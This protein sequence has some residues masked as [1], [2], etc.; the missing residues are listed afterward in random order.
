[1]GPAYGYI[2]SADPDAGWILLRRDGSL[3]ARPFDGRRLEFTG[4][5]I[6]IADRVGTFHAAVQASSS[7]NG[8]L[9]YRV[10]QSE[11]IQLTWTDRNG[12]AAGR[13]GDPGRYPS[14][15]PALSP[16]AARIAITR[17]DPTAA[18]LWVLD[19]S[20][21]SSLQ[22][23]FGRY[24]DDFPVWSPDGRLIA[25]ESSR[26]GMYVKTA[27]GTGEERLLAKA[28]RPFDWSRDGR[29][30]LYGTREPKNKSDLWVLPL[31]GGAGPIPFLATESNETFG[32]FSPDGRWIAYASDE[33]GRDE[34]YVRP[35]NEPTPGS[36]PGTGKWMI[37]R[38]GGTRPRWRRDGK[39]LYFLAPD[40]KVMASGVTA[41]PVFTPGVPRMMFSDAANLRLFDAAPD[42]SKFLLGSVAAPTAESLTVV[43]NSAAMLEK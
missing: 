30:L 23:T 25:F 15:P 37:S 33:S 32:A 14:L 4:E 22:L 3:I 35:F 43:M 11:D 24:V 42:G 6:V 40:G 20:R 5:P 18:N 19:L 39:E 27:D 29:C 10:G 21:G 28:G 2:G 13:A 41:N 36:A 34:V 8:V 9:V 17:G 38:E 26:G 16:D 1:V 12:K 31:E 7:A